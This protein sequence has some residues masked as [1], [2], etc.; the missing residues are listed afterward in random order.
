MSIPIHIEVYATIQFDGSLLHKVEMSQHGSLSNY[1][2]IGGMY[3]I[4]HLTSQ[5]DLIGEL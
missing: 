4:V 5:S 1:C 2:V 3:S